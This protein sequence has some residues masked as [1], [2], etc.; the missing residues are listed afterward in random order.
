M[1]TTLKQAEVQVSEVTK[2]GVRTVQFLHLCCDSATHRLALITVDYL[3]T[4]GDSNSGTCKTMPLIPCDGFCQGWRNPS[5]SEARLP[6]SEL[7]A[8]GMGTT[9]AKHGKDWADVLARLRDVPPTPG[10]CQDTGDGCGHAI[11]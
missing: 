6:L 2:D 10:V 9:Y 1:T 4:K 3:G 5:T 11:T 7:E 8:S